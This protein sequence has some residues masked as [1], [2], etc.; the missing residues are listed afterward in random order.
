MSNHVESKQLVATLRCTYGITWEPLVPGPEFAI[1]SIPGPVWLAERKQQII[2]F[3]DMSTV[4]CSEGIS[5]FH[6]K[7]K[8]TNQNFFTKP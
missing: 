6:N 2:I 3:S 4:D 1:D 7:W 8:F 5:N